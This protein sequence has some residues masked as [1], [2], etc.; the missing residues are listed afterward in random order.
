MMVRRD[1]AGVRLTRNGHDWTGRFPLI[2]E[3]AGGLKVRSFLLDG[4]AVACGHDG[5]PSFDRLRYRRVDAS[6]F[7]FAFDLLELDGRTCGAS[8]S[9][10]DLCAR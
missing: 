9:I 1:S 2:A 6:V 8:R 7:L 5:M 10:A 3:T 4:E